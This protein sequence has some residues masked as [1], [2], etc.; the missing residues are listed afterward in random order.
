MSE[1]FKLVTD[2]AG[3]DDWAYDPYGTAMGLAFDICEVLDAADIEGDITPELFSQWE[4]RPSPC[5]TVPS[6]ETIAAQG[7]DADSFG[8]MCL[9]QAV[10]DGDVT[11]ADLIYAGNV[12][13]RYTAL[14]IAAGRDY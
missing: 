14:L 9:P 11:Q 7:E 13:H 3:A 2:H 12:M 5:V 8:A 4:Y 10:I 1:R 6:L